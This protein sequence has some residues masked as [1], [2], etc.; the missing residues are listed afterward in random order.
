M[1][2]Y[3]P[4]KLALTTLCERPDRRTALTTFFSELVTQSLAQDGAL[5]WIVFADPSA[6]FDFPKDR[7]RMIRWFPGKGL[8]RRLA[9]DHLLTAPAARLLGAS[10]L[11]TVGFVPLLHALPTVMHL[12]VLTHLHERRDARNRYRHWMMA[13]GLRK[14]DLIITNS[15][16]AKSLIVNFDPRCEARL[17]FS[18]EAPQHQLF[19]PAPDAGER[20]RLRAELHI[21]PGFLLWASNFYPYKQAELL[22]RAYALLDAD[23]RA[24]A[25]LIM[26]GG[27]W[28][29]G[30]EAAVAEA[31]ALGVARDV[32]FLG[33]VQDAWLPPL[34]RHAG[35][36]CLASREE[37]FGRCVVE[38]MASGTV[39]VLNDIPV[40]REV[41]RGHAFLVDFRDRAAAANA[42]RAALLDQSSRDRLIP[43]ARARAAEFSFAA[44]A[45]ERMSAIHSML[46]AA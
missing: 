20:E 33:W 29:G 35:A 16:W 41:T 17:T 38:A 8:A 3:H 10:A 26:V 31:T 27:S 43:A 14:A 34:F 28:D 2:V 22:L 23:L 19:H 9:A 4:M 44:L 13:R 21:E 24:R 6:E 7:V 12:N 32:R 18:Y 45:A 30:V 40:L 37:T 1:E 42:L 46:S 15:A 39:C 11:V 5:E 25:P 36:F